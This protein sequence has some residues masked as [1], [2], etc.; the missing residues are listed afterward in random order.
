MEI[1]ITIGG[2]RHCFWIPIYEYPIKIVKGPGPVNYEALVADA[3]LVATI[4]AAVKN[5]GDEGVRNA[6]QAG[7]KNA[8]Q[9]MQKRAGEGVAINM[10]QV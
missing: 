2:K 9:A 6:L 7:V 5:A 10:G 1:C 3:T 4:S 8:V